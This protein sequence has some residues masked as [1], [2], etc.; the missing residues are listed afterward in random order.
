MTL[1][2]KLKALTEPCREV[3]AEIAKAFGQTA[4]V[5]SP[6][7]SSCCECPHY[8][9]NIN[10]VVELVERALPLGVWGA[11][12]ETF[13]YVS[14]VEAHGRNW[15]KRHKLPAVALLLALIEAKGIEQ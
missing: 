10:T 13:G 1:S 15:V 14:F 9:A 7:K 2:Y 11:H 5:K 12:R 8:T 4:F 3:D 6:Y